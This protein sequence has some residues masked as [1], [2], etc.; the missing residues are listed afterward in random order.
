MEHVSE[1]GFFF[2]HLQE[3]E[4]EQ[5]DGPHFGKCLK[6]I[7][8]WRVDFGRGR[9]R[10]VL[11]SLVDSIPTEL[12]EEIRRSVDLGAITSGLRIGLSSWRLDTG[13]TRT[14]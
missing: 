7:C 8:G 5:F 11:L 6:E 4:C 12:P 13:A 9:A 3:L 14:A 2:E 10:Q 1:S